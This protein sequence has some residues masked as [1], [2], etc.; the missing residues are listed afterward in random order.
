MISN[1]TQELI[2]Y[3]F[4]KMFPEKCANCVWSLTALLNSSDFE[5]E[6]TPNILTVIE[7]TVSLSFFLLLFL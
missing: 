1:I 6:Q 2:I 5:K 7:I 3:F 4:K